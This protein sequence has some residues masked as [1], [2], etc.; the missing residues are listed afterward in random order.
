MVLGRSQQRIN[1]ANSTCS[2]HKVVSYQ[3]LCYVAHLRTPHYWVWVWS[4]STRKRQEFSNISFSLMRPQ[5]HFCNSF[6]FIL[7]QAY[8]SQPNLVSTGNNLA[9]GASAGRIKVKPRVVLDENKSRVRN[10]SHAWRSI[11]SV[12][13]LSAEMSYFGIKKSQTR[14]CV[15]GFE[16][17]L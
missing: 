3:T 15:I 17:R 5:G 16:T 8:Q 6:S 12:T 2:S 9:S 14:K 13:V 10:G 11:P 7:C 4:K 1:S